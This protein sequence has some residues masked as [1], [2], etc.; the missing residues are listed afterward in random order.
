LSAHCRDTSL[1]LL[2]GRMNAPA[3]AQNESPK[4]VTLDVDFPLWDRFFMV[5]PLV[6]IGSKEPDGSFDLAPKHMVAPLSWE[7][8]FGFV[9][10]PAHATYRNIQREGVFTVSFPK[11]DQVVLTSLSAAP[12]CD[13]ETNEKP[14]LSALPTIR[15]EKVDGVF[16]QDASLFFECELHSIVDGF[17]INS[18]IAGRIVAAH[19]VPEAL[20]SEDKDDQDVI[21]QAPLLAY[22]AP[23]RFTEIQESSSFPFPAGFSREPKE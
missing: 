8:Y 1:E 13:A 21:R 6:V 5:A 17:G 10:T 20:R 9:C 7:N 4:L 3:S 11:A 22:L 15:A 18:L 23:G 14:S 19:V 12:R 2:E 16:L